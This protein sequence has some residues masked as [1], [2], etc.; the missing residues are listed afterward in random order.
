MSAT[1]ARG[2]TRIAIA[3]V[4]AA[5]VIAAAIFAS[6]TFTVAKTVTNSVSPSTLYPNPGGSTVSSTS[7]VTHEVTSSQTARSTTTSSRSLCISPGQPAGAFLSVL[8]GST[9]LPVVGANVTAVANG[10]SGDCGI[11]T[12][13]AFTW[14]STYVF[15]T[16][17]TEW[18]PLDTLN[19][20]SYEFAVSYSGQT[21]N[22]TVPLGPAVY[23]CGTFYLPSGNFSATTSIPS[24]TA[25]S[26]QSCSQTQQ[27]TSTAQVGSTA[28]PC[29]SPGVY[30]GNVQ[31]TSANLTVSGSGSV[32][33]V[34]L[35]EVGNTYIGSA[36]VYLNGTVIGSPPA[37]EYEPPGNIIL[38][39]Q[40]GQQAVLVLTIPGGSLSVQ[41][42]R[43]Y[44]VLVYAW[45]GS[46]G[47][48]ASSGVSD[49][50][51]ITAT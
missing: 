50:V 30:C 22:Y 32:L 8:N 41:A 4:I 51:N 15:V 20:D 13:S 36:T 49:S 35:L 18:Y 7:T 31:I 39:V 23:T 11:A 33:R 21:Y 47:G 45:V 46:P 17:S 26:A 44:S 5:V 40:P 19:V 42:G 16:N 37:S 9:S 43:T 24:G 1:P 2:Y 48:R 12:V 3:I 29:G 14:Q 34:T 25:T 38:N 6:G 28:S 27:T 10:Y